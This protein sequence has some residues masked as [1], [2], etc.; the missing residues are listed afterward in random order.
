MSGTHLRPLKFENS[1]ASLSYTFQTQDFE[2]DESGD[3]KLSSVPVAGMN[4]AFDALQSAMAPVSLFREIVRF[5]IL[6]ASAAAVDTE[7]DDLKS[8]LRR[9]GRGKLYVELAGGG[10]RWAWARARSPSVILFRTTDVQKQQA[11]V[12]FLREPDW[13]GAADDS[14]RNNITTSPD[15][16]TITNNGNI[17]TDIAVF[18][19]RSDGASGG[20]NLKLENLTN[21]YEFS[22][23]RDLTAIDHEWKVDCGRRSVEFSTDDGASYA[24]DFSLF[25]LGA[26]QVNFMLLEP[27]A[28][29]MRVTGAGASGFDLEWAFDAPFA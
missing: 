24:D 4:G 13:H 2:W 25:S 23:T 27:G 9:I 21:L 11:R 14:A 20:T 15:T 1:D 22:T 16:F 28:N 19:F 8:K 17:P 26:N 12:E 18:R 10:T 7:T 5:R 3:F 6:E 29:S